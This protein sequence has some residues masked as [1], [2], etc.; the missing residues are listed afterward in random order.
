MRRAL[1]AGALLGAIVG[2]VFVH[3]DVLRLSVAWP[4]I[5]G[6]ALWETVGARG[7][8]GVVAGAAAVLGAAAG[9]LAFAIP[10]EFMPVTDLSV[11]IVSGV[12]V[13][14]LVVVGLLAGDRLPLAGMLIGFGAFFGVFEPLWRVSPANFR[15]HGLENLT[16][17]WLGLL[18]GILS[19][20]V[21]RALTEGVRIRARS[22]AAEP[23][24]EAPPTSSFHEMLEGGAG[25]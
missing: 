19:A 11:G 17:V 18:I 5:L 14:V 21:V 1:L 20:A 25:E 6:I 23:A 24:A 12:L 3:H 4:I 22:T 7:S 8:R 10:S 15:T 16:V 2:L 9:W 13:G